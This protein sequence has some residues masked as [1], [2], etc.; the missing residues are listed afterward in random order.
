VADAHGSQSPVNQSQSEQEPTA[1]PVREPV[2]HW[3]VARHHPQ[4]PIPVHAPQLEAAA[5]GSAAQAVDSQSQSAQLPVDGPPDPPVRQVPEEAHHPQVPRPVHAPQSVELLHGSLLPPQLDGNHDHAPVQLPVVGP[6][7]EPLR[8]AP[9]LSGHQPQ[10][11]RSVQS[12]QVPDVAQGSLVDPHEVRVHCHVEQLPPDGPVDVPVRHVASSAQKP[13]EERLVHVSHVVDDAH[14]SVLSQASENQSQ[15]PQ[16]PLDGPKNVPE[17]QSSV[18]SHQP[19]PLVPV[20]AL[21]MVSEAQRS[22][23]VVHVP[24]SQARPA[25]QSASVTQVCE[26]VR[27]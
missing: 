10:P 13:H 18:L 24:P 17:R 23:A 16:L 12:P 25:Q 4:V 8:H 11:A 19:H 7:L 5:H 15:S 20:Q 27:H 9:P 6:P 22:R 26:P 3:P 2:A 14:A 1:G 21:Q